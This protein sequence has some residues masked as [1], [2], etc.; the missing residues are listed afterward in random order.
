MRSLSNEEAEMFVRGTANCS[1]TC[2]GKIVSLDISLYDYESVPL[3]TLPTCLL[4]DLIRFTAVA[5]SGWNNL[6]K[7]VSHT[8][9]L[10][11]LHLIDSTVLNRALAKWLAPTPLIE[12]DCMSSSVNDWF[13]VSIRARALAP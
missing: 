5:D 1:R 11:K 2:C 13:L 3:T 12:Q 6:A 10:C 8:P 4:S 9:Q 7:F